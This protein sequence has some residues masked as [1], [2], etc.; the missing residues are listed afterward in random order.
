[1][2]DCFVPLG[3]APAAEQSLDVA[4]GALTMD[5]D[6]VFL[7]FSGTAQP[8]AAG[9]SPCDGLEIPVTLTCTSQE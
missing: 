7:S 8:A 4:S 3:S 5:G 9:A 1:M 2:I 6:T